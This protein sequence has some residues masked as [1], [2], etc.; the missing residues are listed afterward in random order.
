MQAK[1]SYTNYVTVFLVSRCLEESFGT[2]AG[3]DVTS[4]RGLMA[5]VDQAGTNKVKRMRRTRTVFSK[6][7]VWCGK[8]FAEVRM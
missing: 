7:W 5:C 8:M 6:A 1:C 2:G 3:S 4:S